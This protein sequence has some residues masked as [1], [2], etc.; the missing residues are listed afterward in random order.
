MITHLMLITGARRGEIL[1]L[2]WSKADYKNNQVYI[3]NNILYS[4][5]IGIYEDSTTDWLNKFSERHKLPH[6]FIL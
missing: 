2:K 6:T 4:A 3:C 1:G 5:H